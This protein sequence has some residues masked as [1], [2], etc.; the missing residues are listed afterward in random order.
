[1]GLTNFEAA[2]CGLRELR[3]TTRGEGLRAGNRVYAMQRANPR[4]MATDGIFPRLSCWF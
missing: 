1:M 3:P 2:S 4:L